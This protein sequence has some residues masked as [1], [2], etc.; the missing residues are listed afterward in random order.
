M[1]L[2]DIRASMRMRDILTN[3]AENVVSR[4]RPEERIGK[5]YSYD[6]Q[7]RT[8]RILFAGESINNLVTVHVG[9]N[10]IPSE[11]M[12]T[13][14]N[15]LGDDAPGDLVRV[16]YGAGQHY[17]CD[18]IKGTPT[19]IGTLTVAP[20]VYNQIH[21]NPSFDTIVSSTAGSACNGGDVPA[22]PLPSAW[23]I[24]WSNTSGACAI[25]TPDSS[26]TY[27][28]TGSS[29]KISMPAD[30]NQQINTIPFDVTPGSLV[31]FSTWVRG[32]GPHVF[33]SIMTRGP[34]GDPGWYVPGSVASDSGFMVPTATW[35]K[36]SHSFVVPGGHVKCRVYLRV[37]TVGISG[38]GAGD[39]WFDETQSSM[40]ISPPVQVTTGEI[41]MWPTANAPE[42]YFLC[43]GGTFSSDEYPALATLLGD[44]FGTHSGTTY[45]LP[46]FR[47]RSPMGIG[48]QVPEQLAGWNLNMGA[49]YG[50]VKSEAHT[51]FYFVGMAEDSA[52]TPN[53]DLD[54]AGAGGLPFTRSATWNTNVQSGNSEPNGN[55]GNVHP[56]LGVNFIIK[57]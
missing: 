7:T 20:T 22:R 6:R 26:V 11:M 39:V 33:M 10:M 9:D 42:G 51:H 52:F 4:L 8:A 41:K 16:A 43:N 38:S 18:Y 21:A 15:D 57:N 31:R 34:G 46:D 12:I 30:A 27:T 35:Q 36:L 54:Y 49:K 53:W 23:E 44:T 28:G 56:V 29:V 47:G 14:Y 17:I 3:I 5:V 55:A 37:G 48:G 19:S 25:I 45:Y 50:S 32:N 1:D 40:T 13:T 24:Y 2:D